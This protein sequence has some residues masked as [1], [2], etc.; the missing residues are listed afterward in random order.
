MTRRLLSVAILMVTSGALAQTTT[1][2]PAIDAKAR[3]A[4]VLLQERDKTL[5]D[6][7][8]DVLYESVHAQTDSVTSSDGVLAYN[9]DGTRITFSLRRTNIKE[10]GKLRKA[11]TKQDI[12]YDGEW[13][14]LV[15]HDQKDLQSFQVSPP[16][17]PGEPPRNPLRFDGP[18]PM[19]LG[20]NAD[21]VVAAFEVKLIAPGKEDPVSKNEVRHLRLKPRNKDKQSFELLDLWVDMKDALPVKM[22]VEKKDGG[23]MRITMKNVSINEGKGTT[24]GKPQT[25]KD[26]AIRIKPL[27]QK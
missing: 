25:D 2:A 3:E 20:Q 26:W 16:P 22:E 17:K 18:L 13:L 1:T 10:D 12:I 5:K 21:E 23:I 8:A 11:D 15:D 4:L 6:F 7:I 14:H 24:L 9:N 19:P 27:E